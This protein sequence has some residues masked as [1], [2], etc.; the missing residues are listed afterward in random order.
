MDV[1]EFRR[2]I[3][4]AWCFRPGHRFQCRGSIEVRDDVGELAYRKDHRVIDE[5]CLGRVARGN[6]DRPPRISRREYSRQRTLYR[7]QLATQGELTDKF[8]LI[9]LPGMTFVGHEYAD[10]D[11]QVETAAFL[12]NVGRA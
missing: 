11:R 5:S 7:S 4:P 8:R 10:R 2:A 9:R 6:D 12:G 1:R 3:Q